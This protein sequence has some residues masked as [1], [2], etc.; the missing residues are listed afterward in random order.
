MF[1]EADMVDTNWT[2]HGRE[3]VNCNCSY[4]CPCQFDG[5]PTHGHCQAVAGMQIEK[6]YHG[7]TNLDG[8]SFVG[9]FRWPGAIHEG[10]GEAA[11]VIDERATEAQRVAL[12]RILSG[13]D[14]KPGATIFNV[15]AS[16]F[17]KMHPPIFA[18]IDVESNVAA[19]RGRLVVKG[20]TEGRGEP[21]L[22]PVT[23]AEHRVRIDMLDSNTCLPRS[24]AAG[25]R[26][27]IPS[28]SSSRILMRNSRKSISAKTEYSAE[29]S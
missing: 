22:N 26:S 23:K 4:G 8:L 17:E 29:T 14:T 24:D 20:V 7:S 11:V 5:L 2:I 9:I 18:P 10:K 19:R 3:F 13:Q 1:V 28:S 6:G 27:R 15:F 16:T 12:L 25:P 21:I